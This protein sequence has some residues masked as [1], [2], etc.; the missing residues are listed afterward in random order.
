MRKLSVFFLQGN[1]TLHLYPHFKPLQEFKGMDVRHPGLKSFLACFLVFWKACLANVACLRWTSR[2]FRVLE[3]RDLHVEAEEVQPGDIC[4]FARVGWWWYEVPLWCRWGHPVAWWV[5]ATWYFLLTLSDKK[6]RCAF[7]SRC[8]HELMGA[9]L[10]F[11]ES[12]M[13]RVNEDHQSSK[14]NVIICPELWYRL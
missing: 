13:S 5:G 14:R 6:D 8:H 2:P 10:M 3:H 12:V 9:R 7:S 4:G 1:A 11:V